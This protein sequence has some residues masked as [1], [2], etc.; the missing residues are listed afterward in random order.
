MCQFTQVK[1]LTTAPTR[2]QWIRC[3][4]GMGE[5]SA[6]HVAD[7][8]QLFSNSIY[9]IFTNFILSARRVWPGHRKKK[10]TECDNNSRFGMISAKGKRKVH[11]V[12]VCVCVPGALSFFGCCWRL[13]V[14][15]IHQDQLS[16]FA[17]GFNA[18]I[19]YDLTSHVSEFLCRIHPRRVISRAI[20]RTHHT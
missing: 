8:C 19:A 13:R 4:E 10:R 1:D 11:R 18:R 20:K 14:I 9:Y 6:L 2:F 15:S 3:C 12:C 5:S 17:R 7:C 16:A